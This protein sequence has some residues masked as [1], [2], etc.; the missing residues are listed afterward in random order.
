MPPN[1]KKNDFYL[2]QTVADKFGI[3][4]KTLLGWEKEGKISKAPKDWKGWR[5]Y[6]DKHISQI[7]RVIEM[8]RKRLSA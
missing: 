7:R 6:S 4:K 1:A 8:K 2:A 3:S 5:M